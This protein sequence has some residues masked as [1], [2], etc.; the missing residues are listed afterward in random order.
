MTVLSVRDQKAE[1]RIFGTVVATPRTLGS[2]TAMQSATLASFG[3]L[4]GVATGGVLAWLVIL[5]FSR[6][7]P[8]WGLSAP[9]PQILTVITVAVIVSA[10]MRGAIT[11]HAARRLITAFFDG[12]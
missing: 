7:D 12:A 11:W 6:S 2:M 3:M 8:S 4:L 10:G 5:G 1:L 9:W